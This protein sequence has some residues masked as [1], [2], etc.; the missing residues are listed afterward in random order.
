M[1]TYGNVSA[2]LASL[3]RDAGENVGTRN[4]T[5]ATFNALTSVKAN[6]GVGSFQC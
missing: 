1:W 3:T 6:G 2:T 4:I 5:G